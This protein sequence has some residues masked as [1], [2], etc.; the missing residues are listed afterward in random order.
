MHLKNKKTE[1]LLLQKTTKSEEGAEAGRPIIKGPIQGRQIT[2]VKTIKPATQATTIGE[3]TIRE[4][5]TITNTKDTIKISQI[6]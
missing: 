1:T 6:Q 2:A 5:T 4:T 3:A